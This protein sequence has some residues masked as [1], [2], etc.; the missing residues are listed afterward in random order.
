MFFLPFPEKAALKKELEDEYKSMLEKN[1]Q[2][3]E[4]MEME[5]QKRLAEAQQSVS[6]RPEWAGL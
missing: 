5:F 2:E 4:N 3:M 1:K 6:G